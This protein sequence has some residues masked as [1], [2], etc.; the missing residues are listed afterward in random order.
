MNA[1][2]SFIVA[3][4]RRAELGVSRA[5]GRRSGAD[6]GESRGVEGVGVCH[7]SYFPAFWIYYSV[8]KRSAISFQ[9]SAFKREG[10]G[11]E[12]DYRHHTGKPTLPL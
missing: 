9:Q 8:E 11:L 4:K 2:D 7:G 10:V 3:A 12:D 5:V 6:V 1:C